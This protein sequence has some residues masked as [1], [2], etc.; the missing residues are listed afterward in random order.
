MDAMFSV[1]SILVIEPFISTLLVANI[2]K[3]DIVKVMGAFLRGIPFRETQRSL[4]Q[5]LI[6]VIKGLCGLEIS[7]AELFWV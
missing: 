7:Y 5:C 2:S 3:V 4:S 1:S 6:L